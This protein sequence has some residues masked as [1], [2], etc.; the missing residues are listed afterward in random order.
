MI[1]RA[2]AT[3]NC[4]VRP[5]CMAFEVATGDDGK[6]TGVRYFDAKGVR[7]EQQARVVVV[8]ATAVESARL[9]LNSTSAAHKDGLGNDR[10]LVGRHLTFSTLGKAWGEWD[11]AALPEAMRGE[12]RIHFLQRSVQDLYRI[13]AAKGAYDKG[14]TLNFILP[15]RNPIHTAERL[16]KR[17]TPSL[18]GGALQEAIRRSTQDV[19]ELEVEVFAEFLPNPGTRVTVGSDQDKKDKWGLPVAHIELAHHP[20]DKANCQVLVDKAVEL[21][22]AGGAQT[23]GVQTVGGTTFVLQHGTCRFGSDPGKSVLD[24]NCRVRAA[25]NVYVVDGSFM[26]T[27]GGVPTTW[28]IMANSFRVADHLVGRFKARG[29]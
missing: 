14:G 24:V 16:A 12:H 10:G 23:T 27:S 15:H 13:P 8:S 29:I 5:H 2:V 7:Q 1:P 6:A 19:Q 26:P 9:L 11:R 18:W 17:T 20:A 28:T 3:G 4:E 21:F 22:K 25:D